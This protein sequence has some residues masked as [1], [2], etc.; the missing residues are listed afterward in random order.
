MAWNTECRLAHSTGQMPAFRALSGLGVSAP[1]SAPLSAGAT[2]VSDH[3]DADGRGRAVAIH[4]LLPLLKPV[5]GPVAGGHK[6]QETIWSWV[7]WVSSIICEVAAILFLSETYGP[8]RIRNKVSCLETKANLKLRAEFE[9]LQ[10]N[11]SRSLSVNLIW[12]FRLLGSQPD[13]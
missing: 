11:L 2:L 12:P 1:L 4:T 9:D 10:E 8:R 3:W 7:P 6:T 13:I 5:A